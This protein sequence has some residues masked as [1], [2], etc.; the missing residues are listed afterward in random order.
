[1]PTIECLYCKQKTNDCPECKESFEQH[2]TLPVV[3]FII[4]L[5]LALTTGYRWSV[6]LEENERAQS[7]RQAYLKNHPEIPKK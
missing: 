3:I 2:L 7:L 5:L 4:S 6:A 1:M